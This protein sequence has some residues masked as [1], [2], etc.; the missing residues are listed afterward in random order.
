MS[1]INYT[2]RESMELKFDRLQSTGVIEKAE[3]SDWG[4]PVVPAPKGDR[5]LWLCKDHKVTINSQLLV[6]KC[7][8][9]RPEDLMA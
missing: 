3:H 1:G 2:I 6:N 9:P 4:A 7:P 5:K 8:L